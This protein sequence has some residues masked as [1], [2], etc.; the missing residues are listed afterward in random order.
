MLQISTL[1]LPLMGLSLLP[2]AAIAAQLV[3][4]SGQTALIA[5]SLPVTLAGVLLIAAFRDARTQRADNASLESD[6]VAAKARAEELNRVVGQLDEGVV[7]VDADTLSIDFRSTRAAELI[8]QD[9]CL[10]GAIANALGA[11]PLR[12]SSDSIRAAGAPCP[13]FSVMINGRNIDVAARAMP[14]TDSTPRL[15]L[16]LTDTTERRRDETRLR[17]LATHD[18]VTGLLDRDAL[19]RS[20]ANRLDTRD[21][22][23]PLAL[24]VLDIDAFRT[25]NATLG[26][27]IGDRVL[28]AMAKRLKRTV[29][30]TDVVARLDG[31]TFA[32]LQSDAGEPWQVAP[33][34]A[35]LQAELGKPFQIDQTAVEVTISV[36]AALAPLAMIDVSADQLLARAEVALMEA[37]AADAGQYRLIEGAE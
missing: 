23:G 3:P 17:H 20:L 18:R 8:G 27:S 26:D 37:K 22:T 6:L 29:R 14:P 10:P 11:R 5:I 25:I 12:R 36:G 4:S 35:R 31:D 7:I 33:L 30:D 19:R 24:L 15:A 28:A 16:L 9:P 1:Q 32:V 34:A 2:V 13:P 21:S